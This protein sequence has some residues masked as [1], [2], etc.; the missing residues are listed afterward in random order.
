MD[1]AA[2]EPLYHRVLLKLS[3]EA[4]QGRQS[5]GLCPQTLARLAGEIAAVRALGISVA[6]VVGGGNFFRG[7]K[8]SGLHIHRAH[9]DA[10]G[11]LA[12]VLNGI[13]LRDAL[14]AE[15]LSCRLVS[16]LSMEQVAE[17]FVRHRVLRHLDSGH[18]VLLTAG[19]GNPFFTTDTAAA[20]RAVEI[21]AE[22]FLKATMVDGLYSADPKVHPDAVFYRRVSYRQVIMEDLRVMDHTAI[23]LCQ[24]NRMPI[25]I[26]NLTRPGHLLKAVTDPELGTL[27]CPQDTDHRC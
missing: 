14:E 25:K 23:V 20:L 6:I 9:A 27:I 8:A 18:V 1:A 22:V 11:M 5:F 21:G 19:T 16:A 15:G 3:G 12:T 26:F 13:A 17:T 24:E 10:M 2:P 4:L 7:A